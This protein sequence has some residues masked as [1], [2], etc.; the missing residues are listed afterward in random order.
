MKKSFILSLFLVTGVF[1]IDPS[2]SK[3]FPSIFG[4]KINIMNPLLHLELTLKTSKLYKWAMVD[5]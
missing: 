4:G 5:S 3:K 2:I 1:F